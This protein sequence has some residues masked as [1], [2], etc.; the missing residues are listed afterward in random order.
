MLRA[1]K[2]LLTLCTAEDIR[3]L[4]ALL[5]VVVLTGL[6]EVAGIASILPFLQLAADPVAA[7][8]SPWLARV[9]AAL[10]F[11]S[12]RAM[13]FAAGWAVIVFLGL[14][15]LL[16]ALGAWQR[17]RLAWTI[18]HHV[19][20]SLAR[21]YVRLPY[22][23][24]LE[25]DSGD[26]VKSVIEDVNGLVDGVVVAGCQ[27]LS[28]LIVGGMIVAL[29]VLAD[30][31]VALAA[32]GVFVGTYL[33]MFAL[34][35]AW[36][37]ELGRRRLAANS[38]RYITFVDLIGGIKAIKSTGTGEHFVARFETPSATFSRIQPKIHFSTV[39]P[40]Y[41]VETLAFGA[42]VAVV[43]WLT[44]QGGDFTDV[45]P[46]LT[47]FSLAGYRLMPAA[48][49]AYVS[50]AQ[51]A[52]SYPAIDHIHRD[53]NLD[54]EGVGH[55]RAGGGSDADGGEREADE[56]LAFE[57]EIVLDGISFA[58]A[59]DEEPVLDAV[60]LRIPRGSRVAFVGPS[61]SG[62]TTL[63]DV[64][65]GLLEPAR[66]ALLVDGVAVD[67][68]RRAAWRR[69][70]GYVPQEVFLYNESVARN[71]AF[72]AVEVDMARCA[73][74]LPSRAHRRLRRARARQ[75]LRHAHRRARRQAQRRSAAAHRARAGAVPT[76]SAA[77]ARRGHQRPRQRH[78]RR[79]RRGHPRRTARRDD[80][81][82]RPPAL[83][84][85]PLRAAAR[86]RSRAA[87]RRGRLRGSADGQP[88][89]PG[90]RQCRLSAAPR[91]A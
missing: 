83:D 56:P 58:Y 48:N 71:V 5:A 88:A 76:A 61:G 1:L 68:A 2:R 23:F 40:R 86:V 50:A 60:S 28:Q 29:L 67:G 45:L 63:V 43:L 33:A 65:T 78:R 36:L 15:N 75:G 30:P 16:M 82:D 38:A 80:R 12:P 3:R 24:F 22:R 53:V 81:H 57:R 90:A 74:V 46:M 62:K 42:V 35:R 84:G 55:D 10:G 47:L 73:R 21:A 79:C 27:L 20:M 51:L 87:G 49:T 44:R 34:R 19:S 54:R 70:I 9:H 13:L 77:G 72:G 25:R 66:G 39:A 85:A 11:E 52:S 37:T 8:E 32:I 18:A 31:P 17:Q 91:T 64:L 59:D 26:I 89:V 41:V 69:Q 14:S 7:L 4:W 6:L